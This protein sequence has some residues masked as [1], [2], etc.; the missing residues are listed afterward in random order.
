MA[1][2][3]IACQI[4]MSCWLELDTAFLARAKYEE[5]V[6]NKGQWIQNT[7]FKKTF[8]GTVTTPWVD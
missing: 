3:F 7:K 2:D 6:L 1:P 4:V 5:N 8:D